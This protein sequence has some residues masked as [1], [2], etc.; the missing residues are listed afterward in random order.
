MTNKEIASALRQTGDLIELT[1]GNPYRANAFGRAARTIRGLEDAVTDLV[2]DDELTSV[3]G[4]GDGLSEQIQDLLQ[5]GSFDLRDELLSA[6]PTG[7]LDV[8][9][10]KGLGTKKV[11][12]LWQEL[13]ITSLDELDEAARADQ[14]RSLSGFGKKT[15]ENIIE[16]VALL[17]AYSNR[18]RFADAI[19]AAREVHT[20]LTDGDAFDRVVF[21]GELRRKVETV[22]ALDMV[23]ATS[24]GADH[25][26]QFLQEAD[27]T[28][29]FDPD[30]ISVTTEVEDADA[31]VETPLT[32]GLSLRLFVCTPDAFG[33]TLWRT[34]GS[35]DHVAT[36]IREHGDP[37]MHATEAAIFE[38]AG[39]DVVPPELREDDG[40]WEAAT[41]G[42]LPNLISV[43]DLQGTVHNHS[44]YSDGSHSLRQMAEKA[45]SMGLSY[46]GICDHSQSLQVASGMK[47]DEV[48]RQQDEIRSLNEEYAE[49][50]E[51][52]FRIFSGIESDILRDGSLDY[53]DEI[54]ASF[55]FIVA[56]IHSGF[57][58][59]VNE[60]TERIITAV[61]NPYTSILGHPT[62]RLL[63]VREGYEIDHDRVIDACASNNVAIE[64]NANPYRLDIDWRYIKRAIEKGVLISINPDAHA[65]IELE[66]VRWGVEVARKGWLTAE[67]CLNAKSLDEFEAWLTAR[68]PA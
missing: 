2:Q 42:H 65:M 19:R 57:N 12:T 4:I 10:V 44:T 40:E 17:R 58:M 54:L 55:D 11:R 52:P 63:L 6:V 48:E 18:R 14:V 31:L 7:L 27:D 8:L 45:R 22:Q 21:T 38:G 39:V 36:Y 60:A 68:R 28:A 46:F 51:S 24:D 59:T 53:D 49:N 15:Q 41:D 1:G 33:T 3:N 37:G 32:S 35:K 30:T 67:H 29:P 5:R 50:T 47:P 66:N 43:D 34:T 25:V 23:V 56:S 26:I 20:V 62:G 13:G 61:E 9:K 64:L 16:N